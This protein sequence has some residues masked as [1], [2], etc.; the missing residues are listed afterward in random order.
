MTHPDV[1]SGISATGV[2]C[3]CRWTRDELLQQ[4]CFTSCRDP[5]CDHPASLH[6]SSAVQVAFAIAMA[7]QVQGSTTIVPS[8]TKLPVT[9]DVPVLGYA[10]PPSHECET[11]QPTASEATAAIELAPCA[12]CGRTFRPDRVEKH[13][14]V[15]AKRHAEEKSKKFHCDQCDRTFRRQEQLQCHRT[16]VHSVKEAADEKSPQTA[17]A[18]LRAAIKAGRNRSRPSANPIGA[19]TRVACPHCS[20]N[21]L[22]DRLERHSRACERRMTCPRSTF[23]SAAKRSI[24]FAQEAAQY[25]AQRER[26]WQNTRRRTARQE[27]KR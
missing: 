12:T 16:K 25:W 5:L 26:K 22:P 17:S 21:F 11:P 20:R 10:V 14:K 2:Q 18:D 3:R 8:A 24:G 13:M 1:C 27:E 15:C 7:Q 6:S 4:G 19:V 9:D 23:N